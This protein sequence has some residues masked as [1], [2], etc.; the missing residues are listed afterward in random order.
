MKKTGLSILLIVMCFTAC[1]SNTD[2]PQIETVVTNTAE[3]NRKLLESERRSTLIKNWGEPVLVYE[4]C[5]CWLEPEKEIRIFVVYEKDKVVKIL[6]SSTDNPIG[7]DEKITG[8][9]TQTIPGYEITFDCG[10]RLI[11]NPRFIQSEMQMHIE[12]IVQLI[13]ISRKTDTDKAFP[14]NNLRFIYLEHTDGE[15]MVGYDGNIIVLDGKRYQTDIDFENCLLD[16]FAIP[17]QERS[18]ANYIDKVSEQ[19]KAVCNVC[20]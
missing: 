5:D 3:Q 19:H 13:N 12:Q 17:R 18:V 6:L 11:G 15:I 8:H 2:F 7:L 9:R 16:I 14:L 20:E 10:E 4:N 1:S